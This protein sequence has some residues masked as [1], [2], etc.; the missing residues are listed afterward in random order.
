MSATW[1][2]IDHGILSPSGHVSKRTRK[3]FL[4]R[5]RRELFDGVVLERVYESTTKERMIERAKLLRSL[6]ARGMKPRAYLKEAIRL[7]TEASIL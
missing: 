1:P 6:A 4:E 2:S 5:T 7:E 3:L